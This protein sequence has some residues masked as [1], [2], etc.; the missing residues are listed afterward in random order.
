[1]EK[2]G[3]FY[4][5][6][7]SGYSLGAVLGPLATC[8]YFDVTRSYVLPMQ[9]APFLLL[10]SCLSSS[11]LAAIRSPGLTQATHWPESLSR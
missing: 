2:F 10:A 5:I 8:H 11:V 6:V 9:I 4:G 7:F 1:M 3:L